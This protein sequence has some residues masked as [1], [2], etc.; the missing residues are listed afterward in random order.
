MVE[1]T[2]KDH[3]SRKFVVAVM[4]RDR[5]GIV[6]DVTNALKT[7]QANIERIS[8]TVVMN[9]FTLTFVVN[10]SIDHDA[11]EI[12]SLLASAG[13]PGEFAVSVKNFEAAAETETV[14]SDSDCFVLTVTGHD[15]PS[16]IGDV[17]AYLAGK[18]INIT[19]LYAYKPD[20]ESFIMISQLAVPKYMNAAQIQLDIE[21]L[22]KE[23]GIA[24]NLQ[25]E[26]I[27]KATNEITAPA[28]FFQ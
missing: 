27:F 24:A 16:I 5:I 21:V 14:V 19:D 28:N 2:N 3:K 11:D 20:E 17:A 9:Y 10:F 15:H 1:K 18:G 23:I 8:Q 22:G 25:H 13:S 7:L 12:R 26:N 4:S 6:R